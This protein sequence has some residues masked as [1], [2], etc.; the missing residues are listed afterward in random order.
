M[1]HSYKDPP[2]VSFWEEVVSA[3][4]IGSGRITGY[5]E[6]IHMLE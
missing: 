2:K 3:L 1:G 5:P 4:R 6:V